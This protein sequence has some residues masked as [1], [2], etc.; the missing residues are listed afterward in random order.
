MKQTISPRK[1]L[2]TLTIY[3][4][5]HLTNA[6]TKTKLKVKKK[7]SRLFSRAILRNKKV[8]ENVWKNKQPSESEHV[9]L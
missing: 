2:I 6:T 5:R 7:M 4:T 3:E 9:I 8:I 1:I